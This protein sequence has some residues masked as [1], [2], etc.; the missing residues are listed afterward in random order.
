MKKWE[1]EP[2]SGRFQGVDLATLVRDRRSDSFQKLQ[3]RASRERKFSNLEIPI[4]FRGGAS[5]RRRH[6]RDGP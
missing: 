6:S 4:V 1:G 2:W 5:S 3:N